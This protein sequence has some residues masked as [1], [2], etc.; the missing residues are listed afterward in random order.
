MHKWVADE[1]IVIV[2]RLAGEDMVTYR[3]IKPVESAR[4]AEMKGGTC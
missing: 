3:R 2:K 4:M 1:T